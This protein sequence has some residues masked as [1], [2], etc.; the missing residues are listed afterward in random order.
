MNAILIIV[1]TGLWRLPWPL[2]LMVTGLATIGFTMLYSAAGGDLSHWAQPQ[3]MRF[4]AG[5]VMMI[6]IAVLP[7]S[8]WLR[9]AYVIYGCVMLLLLYVEIS[10]HIGMGAQR[11]INLGFM[12]LQPSEIAKIA[13]ILALARYF[14]HFPPLRYTTLYYLAAP[15]A[16]ILLPVSFILKQPNLGT[17]TLLSG[18]AAWMMFAAGVHR[19]YFI[20]AVLAVLAA[21]PVVWQ[22]LHAYQK[23]R[24]MT[25]LNP[26]EDPLGS[27]YNIAQ[28]IIAIGSGGMS[29]KGLMHG[30]QTQL[31]FLPEKQTD[32]IFTVLA[33]EF[34]FMGGSGVIGIYTLMIL[35]IIGIAYHSNSLFGR[36]VA[37]GVAAMLCLHLFIN[38]G[39]VM[40]LLPVVGIPLPL[41]SYG[42]SIMIS[43]LA[44]CGLAMNS[45]VY[46]AEKLGNSRI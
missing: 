44:A 16:L 19:R 26:S 11:W 9:Y 5:F 38:I 3:M 13:T 15:L 43:V 41:L 39:M 6:I 42:G 18:I 40:G 37:H 24:V 21:T 28:S 4:G 25:F 22:S 34:G 30:S 8:I 29:G 45:W 10:G 31:D 46:R 23:Q 27:G 33:E 20:I 17:A 2:L 32:F 7:N 36:L 35:C 12:T 1:K 14:H